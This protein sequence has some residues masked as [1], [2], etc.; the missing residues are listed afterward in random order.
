MLRRVGV[1]CSKCLGGRGKMLE[2]GSADTS[3][4]VGSLGPSGPRHA[5]LAVW[6]TQQLGFW[7]LQCLGT[8]TANRQNPLQLHHL[9]YSCTTQTPRDS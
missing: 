8:A 4:A 6:A 7:A 3:N 1:S 9:T 2:L 5:R